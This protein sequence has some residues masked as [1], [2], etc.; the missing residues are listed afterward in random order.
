MTSESASLDQFG[1]PRVHFVCVNYHT[2]EDA[3]ALARDLAAIRPQDAIAVDIV[4]NDS[5]PDSVDPNLRK[6]AD[7]RPNIN[8]LFSEHNLGYFGG[9]NWAIERRQSSG[10]VARWTIVS[11]ADIRIADEQL[12]DKL[13]AIC[14]LEHSFGVVAPDV[15]SLE[16]G[17][18]V[19]RNPYMVKRPAPWQLRLLRW[20]FSSYGRYV[21]YERSTELRRLV[22]RFWSS[23]STPVRRPIYAPF[24]AFVALSD[25]FF[26][27]GG[28]LRGSPFLFGEE[29][30]LAEISR[31]LGLAIIF[32]PQ[33]TV[34][35]NTHGAIR[36]V[37]SPQVLAWTRAA[38]DEIVHEF[39]DD[40]HS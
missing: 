32:E 2:D 3:L 36:K 6:L 19:H 21:L 18:T 25:A 28:T 26:H 5:P 11:N 24:G 35:H 27:R 38:L 9:A 20:L 8:L 23:S 40:R 7:A 39:F 10:H 16:D 13:D 1:E 17:R 34:T 14:D 4:M 12:F 37:G 15:T 33:L 31:R 30:F 22:R 29:L